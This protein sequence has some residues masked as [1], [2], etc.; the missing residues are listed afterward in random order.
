MQDVYRLGQS[1]QIKLILDAGILELMHQRVIRYL[2]DQVQKEQH[3]VHHDQ[4]FSH[5]YFLNYGFVDE[6]A[7]AHD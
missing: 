1:K 6:V 7:D 3:C 5:G 2:Q 4:D